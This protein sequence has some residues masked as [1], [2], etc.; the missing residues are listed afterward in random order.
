MPSHSA[1]DHLAQLVAVPTFTY[2]VSDVRPQ[3]DATSL[4]AAVAAGL[5]ALGFVAARRRPQ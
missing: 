2:T 4:W 3:D 5:M 1:N